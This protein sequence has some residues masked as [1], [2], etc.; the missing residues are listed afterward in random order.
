MLEHYIGYINRLCCAAD[1]KN[2]TE[3]NRCYDVAQ[4]TVRWYRMVR[5]CYWT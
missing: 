3:N 1:S 2:W 4:G 5:E